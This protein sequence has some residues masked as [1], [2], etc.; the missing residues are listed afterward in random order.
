MHLQFS[1]VSVHVCFTLCEESRA[2]CRFDMS[3]CVPSKPTCTCRNQCVSRLF[4]D[5]STSHESGR[6]LGERRL[7]T[8]C[9]DL[10]PAPSKDFSILGLHWGPLFMET[11]I[12]GKVKS[13]GN[14]ILSA[15]LC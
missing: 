15:Q 5:G 12:S 11:A 7:H 14:L 9:V 6:E 3:G 13:V 4:A 8:T 1:F 2:T 10:T